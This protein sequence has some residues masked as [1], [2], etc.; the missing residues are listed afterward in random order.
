[1]IDFDSELHVYSENGV[2]IPSVTQVL[3]NSGHIDGRWFTAEARDRGSA[4]HT[5]CERYAKGERVDGKGRSLESLEYVNAFASWVQDNRAYLIASECI[6]SHELNGKRYAGKFDGIYEIPGK[7]RRTLVDV[8]TGA[9]AK[10]HPVQLVAYSLGTMNDGSRVNP[11]YM[12]DLYLRPDGKYKECYVT[13]L[14]AVKA[15][16]EFKEALRK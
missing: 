4:V 8:K 15:I 10:W 16:E 7:G 2:T 3:Q 12:M 13:G 9:R 6:V 14:E 1:M 11:D 5:L